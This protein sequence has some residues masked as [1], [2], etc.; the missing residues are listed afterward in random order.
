MNKKKLITLI[1]ALFISTGILN[2]VTINK[3]IYNISDN[4]EC[5]DVTFSD[6]T[7]IYR[8][9]A[10]YI[11]LNFQSDQEMIEWGIDIVGELKNTKYPEKNFKI[12]LAWQVFKSTPSEP[13]PGDP[14]IETNEWCWMN[15][16]ESNEISSNPLLSGGTYYAETADGKS[17]ESTVYICMEGFFKY[18]V[19]G[20]YEGNIWLN[21][22]DL[23]DRNNPKITHVPIAKIGMIGNK[24]KIV[25]SIT[26][27]RQ[28]IDADLH[29]RINNGNWKSK[30]M[31]L[32]SVL[33]A[34]KS[35]VDKDTDMRYAYAVIDAAEIP[36]N[37]NI[38]YCIET[39][40]GVNTE[41]WMSK[42]SPQVITIS[43][44]T[45]FNSVKEGNLKVEDGNPEDGEVSLNIGEGALDGKTDITIKQLDNDDPQVPAGSG[46]ASSARPVA[47]YEFQP[48][49]LVFSKPVDM[50]LLYLD[51]NDNGMVEGMSGQTTGVNEASLGLFWWDGFDWR[52]VTRGV[53][54]G[55]NTVSG[56]I[57]HFS[58]Y[59]V[60][61]VSPLDASDYRPKERIITP[62]ASIGINDLA[63]FDALSGDYEINIYDIAGRLVKTINEDSAVGSAW[64]G[65]DEEGNIV[66]SGV[67]IY[68]FKAEVDGKMELISGTITVA[69]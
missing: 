24:V 17:C 46:A 40:D 7:D 15:D 59:A 28:I 42:E 57:T 64:D 20:N 39:T 18:A 22:Y 6:S 53:N 21:I 19:E 65:K 48:S 5:G 56:K 58:L 8:V 13:Q 11:K 1:V 35:S 34:A 38:Y 33:P 50:T 47:V 51:L 66:E 49:G 63:N 61:P 9:A 68:Q 10:Q 32:T 45:E 23:T 12:P 30:G 25:A 2:A 41:R 60:F 67:Y 69:K 31:V 16:S 3:Q 62:A 26:D 4:Q 14:N 27:D 36:G 52:L 54:D 43:R 44:K 37:C 29:Y 55:N